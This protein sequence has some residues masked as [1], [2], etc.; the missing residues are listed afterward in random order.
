M[1]IYKRYDVVFGS[2]PRTNAEGDDL[3]NGHRGVNALIRELLFIPDGSKG[4]VEKVMEDCWN[5]HE[6]GEQYDANKGVKARGRKVCIE[7]FSNEAFLIYNAKRIGMSLAECTVIVNEYRQV[8]GAGEPVSYGAVQSFVKKSPLIH[9]QKRATKKSG[10]EDTELPWC[11]SRLAQCRQWLKQF[12]LGKS[13]PIGAVHISEFPPLYI[14]AIAWWDEH[15]RKIRLGFASKFECRLRFDA[16]GKLAEQDE[17]EE[18]HPVTTTKFPGEARGAFG[19]CVVKDDGGHLKGVTMEPFDYTGKQV[20]SPAAFQEKLDAEFQSK[21]GKSWGRHRWSTKEASKK[22]KGLGYKGRYPTTWKEE[23]KAAVVKQGFCD[24]RD[25]MDHV[26]DQS[27]QAYK[28]TEAEGHFMIF[29]DGLSQ[30]WTPDAQAHMNQRGYEHRQMRIL[31]STCDQVDAR[32]RW[33]LVGDS[34]ELCRGLD[35]HGFADLDRAVS[36]NCSLATVY[37]QGHPMRERWNMSKPKELFECMKRTFMECAPSGARVVEDVERITDVL[38]K[39]IEAKGGVVPDEF[40][41]TGRRGRRSD[42]TGDLTRKPTM[43]QRKNT[44]KAQPH[45]RELDDAYQMLMDPNRIRDQW[46][47]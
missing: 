46:G 36:L 8:H 45:H 16:E 28:G 7:N 20:L 6:A 42:G 31:G 44:I 34:P 19:C 38:R 33:K 23:L 21:E 13:V 5:A 2:P 43:R 10:K 35:A 22:K 32:Y 26:I 18:E 12:E 3:W 14:H 41:R 27:E 17:L 40:F 29:H 25:I 11:K 39:I 9:L 4:C 24:V 1:N 37:P 15:H 30:W 47:H